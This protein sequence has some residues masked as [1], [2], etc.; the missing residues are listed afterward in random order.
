MNLNALSLYHKY[1]HTTPLTL[2]QI[3]MSPP[4]ESRASLKCT[5]L[6]CGELCCPPAVS[7]SHYDWSEI[8]ALNSPL[9]RNRDG[10]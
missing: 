6:P 7:L 4:E 8:P 3:N 1:T 5:S 2:S 9:E 10:C